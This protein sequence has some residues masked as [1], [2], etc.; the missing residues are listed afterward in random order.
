MNPQADPRFVVS[1]SPHVHSGVTVRRIMLDVVIAMLP[2]LAVALWFFGW[3]ALRLVSACVVGCV[4]VEWLCRRGMRRDIGVTD[5]SAVVTGMLLAFNLPPT[6]PT[7]M[8]VVGC[9]VAVG[10]G[11]QVFGGIGYNP[12]NPALVGRVAL[13]ISFPV[14][15]T[16][17]TPWRVPSPLSIEAV[18]TATPLGAVKT[19]L[20][21]GEPMPYAFDGR[22]LLDFFL[23][24][25][26]GCLGEVSAAALLLGAAY[27]LARG[28]ISWHIPVTYVGTVALLAAA[29]RATDPAHSI[30]VAA[31]LVTGG[32]MLGALYMATDMVTSP[33]TKRG[34]L[35]FGAGCGV[36]TFVIRQW[37]GYP[38]GVSFSILLMNAC[39]PLI[40][41][42]TRPRVFGHGGRSPA[43]KT[44]A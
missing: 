8:A 37:G 4:A 16:R 3:N 36:L 41:R 44:T 42:Y 1:P 30:P 14:A 5:L 24:N 9:A 23:G 21:S 13:T 40:N 34:H 43:R 33:M 20:S 22:T 27:L 11:K 31:H 10:L 39:T 17:W 2:A 32:L 18:T 26:N 28:W 15:M 25:Q 7:W 6:L 38:E 35:V 29:V 12:F 19:A